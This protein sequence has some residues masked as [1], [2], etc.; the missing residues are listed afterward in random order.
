[1]NEAL[2]RGE[3]PFEGPRNETVDRLLIKYLKA[4]LTDKTQTLYFQA[5]SWYTK[6]KRDWR[7]FSSCCFEAMAGSGSGALLK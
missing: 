1:M 7:R 6:T 4:W 5:A 2:E 3:R